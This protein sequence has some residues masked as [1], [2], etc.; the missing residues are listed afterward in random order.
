M[1]H[2]ILDSISIS[3]HITY[4]VGGLIPKTAHK[5]RKLEHFSKFSSI[6][7]YIHTHIY[8]YMY[9]YIYIYIIYIY[10]Y[11]YINYIYI[12]IYIY[13][14]IH[15]YIYILENFSNVSS[16]ARRSSKYHILG[17]RR[18]LLT[19]PYHERFLKCHILG[20][21]RVLKYHILGH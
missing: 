10:I 16:I 15:T 7:P 9:I 19:N 14:Y 6:V 1:Y 13:T 21:R 20:H 4:H 5:W 8:I 3:C 18:N 11:I 12:Y 17:H 2:T